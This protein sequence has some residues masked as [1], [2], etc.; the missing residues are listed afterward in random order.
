M[1]P[2]PEQTL[3]AQA[4]D[5]NFRDRLYIRPEAAFD[6]RFFVFRG[7]VKETVFQKDGHDA[8]FRHRSI[9][10]NKFYSGLLSFED[11]DEV[12]QVG[13]VSLLTGV[14]YSA[15]RFLKL[16]FLNTRRRWAWQQ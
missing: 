7:S 13:R 3:I 1:V 8:R 14:K 6:E 10:L 5:R 16:P 9:P 2:D 11:G 4:V 12:L 15:N